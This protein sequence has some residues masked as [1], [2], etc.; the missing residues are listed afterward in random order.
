LPHSS[1]LFPIF[2]SPNLSPNCPSL[3]HT[4]HLLTSLLYQLY[5]SPATWNPWHKHPPLQEKYP[6]THTKA[7]KPSITIL[8]PLPIP[9]A[10]PHFNAI[11]TNYPNFYI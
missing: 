6:Q 1:T 5:I 4:Y 3:L 8:L 7:I 9:F 11:F 2:T 10:A